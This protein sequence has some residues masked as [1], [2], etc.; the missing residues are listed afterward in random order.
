M[1]EIDQRRSYITT[2]EKAARQ[3]DFYSLSDKNLHAA[4]VPPLLVETIRSE[5]EGSAAD[6][7]DRLI[8]DGIDTLTDERRLH[9]ATFLA[10]QFARGRAERDQIQEMVNATSRLMF[11]GYTDEDIR[12]HLVRNG[13]QPSA[14][15]IERTRRFLADLQ[16]GGVR[17]GSPPAQAVALALSSVEQAVEVFYNREWLIFR[18]PPILITCDEP[19]IVMGGP[20]LPRGERAG[21]ATAGIVSFPLS[22]SRL[23]VTLR[24][25]EII[26][27]MLDLD[28][29][30][31]T[32]INREVLASAHR[33]AFERPNRHVTERLRVPPAP[34]AAL[35]TERINAMVDGK[36]AEVY[37]NFA[38][39]RWYGHSCMPPWPVARWW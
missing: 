17:V 11:E 22:P 19:I 32:D 36:E 10:F 35:I 12:S 16:S 18:A 14:V 8:E 7:V 26:R 31:V 21:L 39:N 27:G 30:E 15:D 33:Y 38:I 3:T 13:A 28:H 34:D 24:P 9:F 5:V 23:L 2:P 1:T 4:D 6:I 20:G 29:I 37:R 25:G